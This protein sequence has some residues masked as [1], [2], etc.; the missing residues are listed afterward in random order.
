MTLTS[1]RRIFRFTLL[2]I[3]G[4]VLGWLFYNMQARGVTP[5]MLAPSGRVTVET[6]DVGITFT[7]TPDTHRTAL[8]FFPGSMVET[9]A[10]VPMARAAAEAGFKVA[11][12]HLPFMA[13]WFEGARETAHERARAFMTQDANRRW[14]AGGHSLGG[15]FALAVARESGVAIDGLFLVATT[16]PREEDMRSLTIPVMK[17]YGTADGL[18]SEDEIDTFGVNLPVH[19][20]WVRVEGANHAQF[21]WYGRQL[22]DGRATITR[23]AQ[24]AALDDALH[25]MLRAVETST[26]AR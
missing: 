10:Y 9:E 25:R 4:A 12:V 18:A 19:T 14:V 15:K 7:P 3:W 2:G 11:L 20:H 6:T 21:A 8:V 26:R 13:S 1:M 22:G 16:H 17:V 5:A 24:Q 23:E